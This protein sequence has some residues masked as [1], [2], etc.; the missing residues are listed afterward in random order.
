MSNRAENVIETSDPRRKIDD[1]EE[2]RK[3]AQEK[4]PL[5]QLFRKKKQQQQL[6]DC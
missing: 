5:I 1:R 4:I 6:V 3:G 2:E